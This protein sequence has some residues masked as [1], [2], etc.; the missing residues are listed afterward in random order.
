MKATKNINYRHTYKF[1]I[2]KFAHIDLL[3]GLLLIRLIRNPFDTNNSL[4]TPYPLFFSNTM[5]KYSIFNRSCCKAGKVLRKGYWCS[6][7]EIRK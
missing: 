4:R 5:I 1:S 7:R 2:A 6:L 3:H